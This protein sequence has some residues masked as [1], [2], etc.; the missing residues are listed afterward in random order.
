[1]VAHDSRFD[2]HV[3]AVRNGLHVRDG[4]ALDVGAV[5]GPRSEI[6][7]AT[8]ETPTKSDTSIHGSVVAV[9]DSHTDAEKAIRALAQSGF[10]MRTLS[11]VGKDYATEEGVVG[12]TLSPRRPSPRPTRSAGRPA[13]ASRRSST[14]VTVNVM[15]LACGHDDRR[16]L[17]VEPG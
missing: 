13:A 4:I 9:Y 5:C 11:I 2:A 1:M 15:P 8:S 3:C 14:G 17:F 6:A 10:D 12:Q 7:A 16:Q